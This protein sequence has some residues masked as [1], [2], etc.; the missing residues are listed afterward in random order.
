MPLPAHLSGGDLL[1]SN[2]D[3]RNAAT[4]CNSVIGDPGYLGFPRTHRSNRFRRG[5]EVGAMLR[6]PDVIIP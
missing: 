2:P 4:V 1:R 5:T 6:S 3:P